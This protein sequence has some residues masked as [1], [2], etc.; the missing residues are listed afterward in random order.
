MEAEYAEKVKMACWEVLSASGRDIISGVG[1]PCGGDV[2]LIALRECEDVEGAVAVLQFVAEYETK[3]V[4]STHVKTAP[5]DNQPPSVKCWRSLHFVTGYSDY[6]KSRRITQTLQSV[7]LLSEISPPLEVCIPNSD[8]VELEYTR[9]QLLSLVLH[10]FLNRSSHALNCPQKRVTVLGLG[11]GT[12]PNY[13]HKHFPN[14]NCSVVEK[15]QV[16]IEGSKMFFGLEIQDASIIHSCAKDWMSSEK[17][18]QDIIIN[19]VFTLAGECLP[20]SESLL[21]NLIASL[22]P[23]TVDSPSS[24]LCFNLLNNTATET[25]DLLQANFHHNLTYV[26]KGAPQT[27]AF[28]FS[29]KQL[30]EEAAVLPTQSQFLDYVNATCTTQP[31]LLKLKLVDIVENTKG[32]KEC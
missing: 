22:R 18:Q 32:W 27:I 5:K 2:N 8:I 1:E 7:Q 9:V 10:G 15:E 23:A 3:V 21:K 29:P 25:I 6:C 11:A 14:W 4:N 31:E 17:E 19:D 16:V 12:V 28:S 20:V 13:I 24:I 30:N 26:A